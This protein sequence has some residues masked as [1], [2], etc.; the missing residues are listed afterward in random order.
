MDDEKIITLYNRRDEDAIRETSEKYGGYCFSIANNILADP[1]DAEECVNDTWLK[2][3]QSIPP[4]CPKNLKAFLAKIARSLALNRYREKNRQK[5]GGGEVVLA[6][7]EMDEFLAGTS[8]IDTEADKRE[9]EELLNGF[10]YS[11]SERD[12]SIF[13]LRYFYMEGTSDIAREHSIRESNV[14]MILSRTRKKLR[15]R[16]EKEGYTIRQANS[17]PK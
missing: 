8:D 13:I 14:L 10:L 9:L 17:L 11:L 4:Q 12:R 15:E 5:R 1:Q 16:L 3:W 2:V 7:E 6:F